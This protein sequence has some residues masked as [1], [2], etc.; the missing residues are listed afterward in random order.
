MAKVSV[1]IPVYNVKQYLAECLDSVVNQTMKDLEI[2]C[3][4]DGSND[5]SEII[6]DEYAQK[7]SRFHVIHKKNEGY[8][9]ALNVAMAAATSAYIGIVESDDRISANMYE[10][11]YEVIEAYSADVVK[12]D[13]YEFYNNQDGKCIEEYIPLTWEEKYFSLYNRV[14]NIVEHEDMMRFAKY[15]W[16]GLYRRDFLCNEKILHN[17]TPG[18]SYQDNGFWFQTMIKSKAIYFVKK[19]YYHY[20]IDN[21]NSSVANTTKVLAVNQEYDFIDRILDDM[22]ERGVPFR[23]WSRYFRL[24]GNVGV[25]TQLAQEYKEELAQVTKQE[26]IKGIQLGEIKAELYEGYLKERLFDLAANIPDFL[27]KDRKRREKIEGVTRDYSTL[28]LYG[29]GQ[30][31]KHVQG[32][33]REGRVNTKIGYFA[34]SEKDNE[35][36]E[37]RGIPVKEIKEL[38][39]M[40][41]SALVIISVGERYLKEIED[42]LQEFGFKHCIYYKEILI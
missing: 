31:G 2:I 33:L 30:I 37:V 26:Y 11:L 28:I 15:T 16:S 8:G 32:M 20:R 38:L 10:E 27:E 7:D 35:E 34:V 5:G 41:E 14:L 18:A 21:P 42:K 13:H 6:L 36:I 24:W 19:A 25:I 29:A 4:D 1:V 12:A 23:K 9:K 39:K 22:G 40:R 17:E 3:V